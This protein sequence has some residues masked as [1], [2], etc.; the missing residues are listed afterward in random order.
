[1]GR[2]ERKREKVSDKYLGIMKKRK[3]DRVKRGK[4]G[5]SERVHKRVK[6]LVKDHICWVA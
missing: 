3:R 6:D 5:E 2:G 1:M 4:R